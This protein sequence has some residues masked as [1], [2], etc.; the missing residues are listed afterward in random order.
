MPLTRLE[1]ISKLCD[2]GLKEP[3]NA[4]F[5]AEVIRMLQKDEHLLRQWL[6]PSLTHYETLEYI[7]EPD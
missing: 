7:G 2:E 3:S 6:R 4:I 1:I 5:C